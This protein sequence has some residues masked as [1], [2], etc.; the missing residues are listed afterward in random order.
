MFDYIQ[1]IFSEASTITSFVSLSVTILGAFSLLLSNLARYRQA[2]KLGIPIRAIYQA[3]IGDSIGIWITLLSTLG[4]G[5][6]IPVYFLG[7]TAPW[8]VLFVVVAVSCFLAQALSKTYIIAGKDKEK[9]FDGKTYVSQ[10][11]RTWITY[12]VIALLTALAYL[13]IHNYYQTLQFVRLY[14]V[15]ISFFRSYFILLYIAF[16]MLGIYALFILSALV[17]NILDKLSG[18]REKMVTEIDGKTYLVAMRNS[19]YHWVLVPCEFSTVEYTKA[20]GRIS[21]S[22]ARFE[23]GKFIICD[24][25]NPPREIKRLLGYNLIDKGTLKEASKKE[26]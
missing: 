12:T 5:V 11:D 10:T 18:G 15:Q 21:I 4:L 24:M 25:S 17:I 6:F 1:N 26:V 8:W 14:E 2:G 3:S 22:Y 20:I 16:F 23:K 7:V 9:I 19:Q 13:H